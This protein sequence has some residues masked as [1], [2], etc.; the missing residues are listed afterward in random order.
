MPPQLR[1]THHRLDDAVD[2]LY[3]ATAFTGDRD[4]AEH[5]SGFTSN[6]WHPWSLPRLNQREDQGR[7]IVKVDCNGAF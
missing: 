4:R 5:L 2:K 7:N 3:R 6:S 1:K